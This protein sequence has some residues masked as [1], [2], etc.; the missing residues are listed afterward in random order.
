MI[1]LQNKTSE[2]DFAKEISDG[3]RIR[4]GTYQLRGSII[5]RYGKDGGEEVGDKRI[6][7]RSLIIEFSLAKQKQKEYAGLFNKLISF[8]GDEQA[9]FY[10]INTETER[11]ALVA[12][13]KI[14]DS[15]S[16]ENFYRIG[17]R[18]SLEFSM[19]DASWEDLEPS[20]TQAELANGESLQIENTGELPAFPIIELI[21][22]TGVQSFTLSNES[23][24]AVMTL[25]SAAFTAGTTIEVNNQN[26]TI[27]LSNLG[28]RQ[29]ITGSLADGTGFV[30][31]RKGANTLS[32]GSP[33]GGVRLAVSYR[34]RYAF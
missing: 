5:D 6:R 7:A 25:S 19:L 1:K 15:S 11:R 27:I 10:I 33:F 34:R 30:R 23:T 24:G 9:P 21:A 14:K 4:H 3:Y 8:F 20:T 16:G 2:L 22:L 18:S 12:L 13:S 31:L 26:G 29:D 28:S 17:A 32:Y